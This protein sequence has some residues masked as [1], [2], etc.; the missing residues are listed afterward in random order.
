MIDDILWRIYK[1]GTVSAE[2]EIDT[3]KEVYDTKAQL[4][5]LITKEVIGED[6]TEV[7]GSSQNSN[8]PEYWTRKT[9]NRNN[10]KAEQ[11]TKLNELFEGKGMSNYQCF[12]CKSNNPEHLCVGKLAMDK[13]IHP[14]EYYVKVGES[15][16]VVISQLIKDSY[17]AGYEAG[18]AKGK[19]KEK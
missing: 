13:K 3:D 1:A 9:A 12:N 11:R 14:K 8:N 15:F 17:E 19:I 4:F 2:R 16:G 18:V 7:R 6:D 5:E 10:L